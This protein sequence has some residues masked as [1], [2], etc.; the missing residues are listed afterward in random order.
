MNAVTPLN[1]LPTSLSWQTDIIILLSRG[2]SIVEACQMTQ[3]SHPSRCLIDYVKNQS[4]V[5]NG[6]T[7]HESGRSD[8]TSETVDG[9]LVSTCP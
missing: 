7:F 6:A 8:C 9:E 1:R 3:V 5:E 4:N 2:V